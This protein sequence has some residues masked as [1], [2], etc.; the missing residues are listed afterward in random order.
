MITISINDNVIITLDDATLQLLNYNNPSAE[1]NNIIA[2]G[3]GSFVNS[4]VDQSKKQLQA[5][6][7]PLIRQR[8]NEMPTQDN[9]IAALIYSQ[10]DYENYDQRHA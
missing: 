1:I 9:D 5:E 10:P 2:N 8:Y 4:L 3:I 7:I 6:W